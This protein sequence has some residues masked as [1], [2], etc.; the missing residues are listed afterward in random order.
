MSGDGREHITACHRRGLASCQTFFPGHNMH[1][2]HARRTG[3]RPWGWRDAVV[4]AVDGRVVS[5][6]YVD[7]DANPVVWHHR[8]LGAVLAPGDPVRLHERCCALGCPAGWFNVVVYGGIGPVAR[9]ADEAAWRNRMTPGVVE[10][11]TG[12][13]VPTDHLDP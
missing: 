2:I 4:T 6:S 5:L 11:R 13:A 3:E 9:P 12:T 8:R 1:Q 7:L 10:V